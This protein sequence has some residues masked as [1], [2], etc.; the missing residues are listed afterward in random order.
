MWGGAG[1]H[2]VSRQRRA[3]IHF[4]FQNDHTMQR[5]CKK[6]LQLHMAAI[7]VTTAL[8]KEGWKDPEFEAILGHACSNL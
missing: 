4:I 1:V 5:K 2:E 6:Q 7:P 8:R 3:T